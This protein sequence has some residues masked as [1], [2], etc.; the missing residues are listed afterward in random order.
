MNIMIIVNTN[1]NIDSINYKKLIKIFKAQNHR[2]LQTAII[3]ILTR[4]CIEIQQI[5]HTTINRLISPKDDLLYYL[6]YLY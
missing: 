3:Q 2:L 5:Y 4:H 6:Y 1:H